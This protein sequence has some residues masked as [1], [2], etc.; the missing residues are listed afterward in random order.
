LKCLLLSTGVGFQ[1]TAGPPFRLFQLPVKPSSSKQWN[2][3]DLYS[4]LLEAEKTH[5]EEAPQLFALLAQKQ[6]K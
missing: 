5:Y 6:L 1:P 4:E 3:R 2:L